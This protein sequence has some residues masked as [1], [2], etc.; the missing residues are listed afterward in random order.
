MHLGEMEND[1]RWRR[2]ENNREPSSSSSSPLL[3]SSNSL[4]Y[5]SM[6]K[7]NAMRNDGEEDKDDLDQT[8]YGMITIQ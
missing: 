2:G 8:R 4:F 1:R 6:R 5:L 7:R 3:S